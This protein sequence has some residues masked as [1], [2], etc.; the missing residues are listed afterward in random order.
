MKNLRKLP[1]SQKR[2]SFFCKE[3]ISTVLYD[4]ALG[5]LNHLDLTELLKMIV[6]EATKLINTKHGY[7]NLVE[8]EYGQMIRKAGVG[9]Y[10]ED[11]N[12]IMAVN[13]GLIRKTIE[14]GQI[15]MID[16]YSTWSH[17]LSAPFFD[18]INAEMQVPIKIE[19]KIVGVLGLSFSDTDRTFTMQDVAI[20]QKFAAIASIAIYNAMLYSTARRVNEERGKIQE[21]LLEIT[22]N[23]QDVMSK[24]S[25]SGMI[26]YITPSCEK[27]TGYRTDQ[28]V[29]KKFLDFIHPEDLEKAIASY[30]SFLSSNTLGNHSVCYRFIHASGQIKWLEI[31]REK[32]YKEG[33]LIGVVAASRDVSDRIQAQ[34]QATI[35]EANYQA[36]FSSVN[37]G[38]IIYG[39]ETLQ[40][41]DANQKACELFGLSLE[42]MLVTKLQHFGTGEFPY[43][44]KEALSW[45]QKAIAGETPLYE[46]KI[47]NAQGDQLDLEVNLK[48][49]KLGDECR[50]LA[51]VRD[52]SE[53]A[54]A[55]ERIYRLV[56]FDTLTKLPNKTLFNDR[57]QVALAHAKRNGE[58]LAVFFLDLDRFKIINDSL[59]H[60]MG[61]LVLQEV[62]ERL[63]LCIRAEDT[64]CRMSADKFIIILTDID[65]N[66]NIPKLI[67]RMSSTLTM[68]F[69]IH[70]V[71]LR[72]TSSIGISFYPDNGH[73]PEILV[74]HAEQAMYHAKESGRNKY[75]FFTESLNQI[76]TERLSLENSLRLAIERNEFILYYQ[77]QINSQTNKLIGVEAL[78]RW[79][80]PQNGL[81]SPAKFIPVAEETGLIIPIGEWVIREVCHQHLSWVDFGLPPIQIAVNV[82]AIQF[83]QKQFCVTLE[84][85]MSS[86]KLDPTYLE[87]ELTEGVIMRDAHSTIKELYLLKELGVKLSIDD[88]GTGY[89]SLRYLSQFPID[90]LKIDQSFIRSMTADT[91]SLA[92]VESI[93]SLAEK[94]KIKVIAEGVETNEELKTLQKCGCHEVQGYY[95]SK[96][97]P[98]H[99]FIEWYCER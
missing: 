5:L 59:G 69:I 46:W 42:Q 71:E 50:I 3:A 54:S 66:S 16:D 52:I 19:S 83:G 79:E 11:V 29:G 93:I 51:V 28:L 49:T 33:K 62:A 55:K 48:Y 39:V 15:T 9:V 95:F 99:E 58:K 22:N 80:H 7:Y 41:I 47:R 1:I 24:L 87:I 92:I 73:T 4:T 96:P 76:A 88:F 13:Q 63:Q 6:I 10:Q 90:K 97:L 31:L 37:D 70:E 14:T 91:S 40:I 32:L 21:N 8:L 57:L 38:I 60:D 27:L 85:I 43:T 67:S 23:M 35:L 72:I 98:A 68:P 18:K 77:P 26:E 81:I 20:F 44:E 89:S 56:N 17:R 84:E 65:T 25:V 64:L 82:S 36:I 86:Y 61:D 75:Q 53:R 30:T 94:L 74:K 45:F 12:R 2:R 78:I 34:Q